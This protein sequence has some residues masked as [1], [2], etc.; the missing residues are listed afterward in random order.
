M[1]ILIN[2]KYLI[3]KDY[4]A[5]CA[6]GKRGIGYKKKEGDL[7][8]PIGLFKIKYI[9]YRKDRIKKLKTKLK[10]IIIN[11]KMGWC[12]DPYSKHYNKL[13]KLPSNYSHEKIY[14]KDNIYDIILVLNYNMSPIIKNKGS[15]IFIH[16]A[17]RNLKK[18]EG[19]IALKKL[20]LL[21]VINKL[22]NNTQV[23]ILNQK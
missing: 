6:I 18:T 21:K 7:I 9:L 8:T 2:K 3:Y 11:K 20:H 10:K 1:H 16:I 13:I 15:A 12:N 22:K 4:K 5:K 19:C 23:K 14:R 17:R